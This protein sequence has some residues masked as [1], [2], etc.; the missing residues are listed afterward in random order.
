MGMKNVAR[1][2]VQKLAQLHDSVG[3]G[4]VMEWKQ[5]IRELF[6]PDTC[7]QFAPFRANDDLSVAPLSYAPRKFQQLALATAQTEACVDMSDFEGS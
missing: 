3:M 1:R 4:G 7:F 5:E 6:R 2:E